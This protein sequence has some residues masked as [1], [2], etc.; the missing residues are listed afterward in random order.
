M[1]TVQLYID[2]KWDDSA[3]RATS[4]VINPATGRAFTAVSLAGV[5][6]LERA[7]AAAERGFTSWKAKTAHERYLV[8]R[9]AA[10]LLRARADDIG[11]ALTAEQGK[12]LAEA[13]IETTFSA[14]V[15]DWYAEEGKRIYGRA[16]P[17]R[18]QGQT[19]LLLREPVGPVVAF[20]PWNFPINQ[21]VRKIAGAMAAGCSIVLKGPEETPASC[22]AL[23]RAFADAGTPPGVLNLVYGVPAQVSE[24][25][26]A[27]PSVRKIS[28][29]GSTAVGKI[30]A[31]LAGKH[32]K[33]VTMELGGHAP[34]IV[35][36]DA[37]VD[38]AIASLSASKYRNAG[39]QCNSPTRFLVQTGIYDKFVEAFATKVKSIKVMDGLEANAQM[40]PLANARRLHAMEALVADAVQKGAR[41]CAGGKRIG[42][43]GFFYEPTVMA[44]VPSEARIM[45]EEPFGPVAPFQRFTTVDDAIRE[46]NRL[47]YGLTAYVFTRSMKNAATIT[48]S[49]EVGAVW[50]NQPG[51]PWP[52]IPFGGVKDS[53]YGYEGGSEGLDAYLTSKVVT[54]LHI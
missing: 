46:A 2:G 9:K 3:E 11:K 36:D 29:T 13:R 4:D 7:V 14:D 10:E 22:A 47:A 5:V 21:A 39:Q 43:N 8:M 20:T 44:D 23:V 16:I 28:F 31:S 25:L 24:Y 41:L 19:Q 35:C 12:P 45:N 6:D 52:E 34:V 30:L 51:P 54:Q 1:T 48:A 50:I 18:V 40:G 26:I 49:L 27:H 53:G 42:T 33:R 17:S 37:D 38:A 32:M 15:I